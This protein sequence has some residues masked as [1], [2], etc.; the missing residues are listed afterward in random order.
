MTKVTQYNDFSCFAAC[1]ES[2]LRDN[3]KPFDH[4]KFIQ[5]NLD[6]FNRGQKI[7]GSCSMENFAEVAKRIGLGFE[8]IFKMRGI[9]FSKPKETILIGAHWLDKESDN[10]VVR[11]YRKEKKNIIVMNPRIGDFDILMP[12][13]IIGIFKFS[14]A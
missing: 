7:E 2:F 4:R 8:R 9:T 12:E 13:W 11:Y 14:V 3:Q 5:D 10:H 1:L 6:L